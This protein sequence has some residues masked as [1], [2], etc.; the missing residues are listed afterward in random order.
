M[1]NYDI[2]KFYSR[3]D[4]QKE[5]IKLSKNREV[6]VNFGEKGYGKRPDTLEYENDILELAKQGATSFHVSLERFKDPLKLK[7]G[8]SQKEL[9][10]LRTGFDIIIDLDTK[11]FEISKI[12]AYLIIEALK[13][14]NVK[15]ISVKF[16]GNNGMHIGIPFES[17][18]SRVNNKETKTLFPDGIKVV[19]YYLKNFI[20]D[21]LKEKIIDNFSLE[22]ISNKLKKS[23]NE[24]KENNQF[25]PFKVIDI[26]SVLISPRHLFRS[27]Y[28]IN[29]KSGLVSMPINLNNILK[30]N[31]EDAKIEKIKIE[32]PF[33][34]FKGNKADAS[35]LIIQAFD[36]YSKISARKDIQ[37]KTRKELFQAKKEY[38]IPKIAIKEEFFPPC[39]KLILQGI[40]QDGRKRA[41]FI[42]I[43]FLKKMGWS[44]DQIQ[45]R[46]LEWNK[47][48]YEPLREGYIISQINWHKRQKQ[49]IPPPNC[50]NP[51][52]YT[53]MLVCK[54][55]FYCKKIK[56]P[57]QH[58]MK[59]INKEN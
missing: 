55:D 15:N 19:N 40:Q 22:D 38:E 16:S 23:T 51:S 53:G 44:L 2:L 56:N 1:L 29:E 48:N 25:N 41:I 37:I 7:T 43:N 52:Y 35:D 45:T 27:V 46:L 32:E 18:P 30:F 6:A 50:D 59:K 47:V 36:F 20:K 49:E 9:E 42:L 8:M 33:L 58:T 13:F 39:I 21:H 28:S 5:I 11:I 34:E 10:G 14:H 12:C 17:F 54:P 57:I 3:K 24:L 26:D 4:I 31:R